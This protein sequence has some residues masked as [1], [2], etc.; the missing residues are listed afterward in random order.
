M[1]SNAPL[2]KYRYGVC[3]RVILKDKKNID[4]TQAIVINHKQFSSYLGIFPHLIY[5][6]IVTGY[7]MEKSYRF[8]DYY[9]NNYNISV[10]ARVK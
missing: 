8:Q 10:V 1:C 2:W 4:Q 9:Y 5:E 6:C 7:I 3:K